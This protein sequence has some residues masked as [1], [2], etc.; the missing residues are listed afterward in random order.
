GARWVSVEG[1]HV[2]LKFLGATPASKLER[3]ERGVARSVA[4][5]KP[6]DL[7]LGP[8]GVFPGPRRARVLWASVTD[9]SGLLTNLVHRLDRTLEPLGYRREKRA[10]SPHLTLARFRTPVVLAEPLPQ[11]PSGEP[12]EAGEV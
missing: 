2:T 1:Q 12:F 11:I 5:R 8:L 10:Y 7:A 4:G 6:A 3:V 9:G